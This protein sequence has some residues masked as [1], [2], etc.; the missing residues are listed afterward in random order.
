MSIPS[1]AVIV[2]AFVAILS[3]LSGLVFIA[4]N[5]IYR[6]ITELYT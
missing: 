2:G 6:N 5:L 1:L 3:G 4:G